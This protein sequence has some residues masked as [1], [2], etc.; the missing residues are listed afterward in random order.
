MVKK[1]S[2]RDPRAQPGQN[3]GLKT[4]VAMLTKGLHISNKRSWISFVTVSLKTQ[5][6]LWGKAA[7]RCAM[8]ACR[9]QLV[10]HIS[11]TDDPT[12]VGENCHIVAENDGG[13][14]SEPT[15]SVNDRNRYANLVLLCNVDH[16]IVDDN[17]AIWTA[18]AMKVLKAEHEAWVEGSLGLDKM[19]LRDETTYAEYVDEWVRLAHLNEWREWSSWVLGG[20][21]PQ[22]CTSVD[23]DLSILRRWLLGRVWP[24]RY[25]SLENAFGNFARV[26][27]DFQLTLH[28]YIEPRNEDDWLCTHK[29]YRIDQWDETLYFKL[30]VKYE[31]HVDIVCDLM[32]ELTRASNL[33]CHEVRRHVAHGFRLTEGNLIVQRG[34]DETLRVVE[35]VPH[36][37]QEEAALVTPYPGLPKFFDDRGNR[38]RVIGN[39]KPSEI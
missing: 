19:K 22:I 17:E 20:D 16:K 24:N 5:K 38:D 8:P 30:L 35:F 3:Q 28:K 37:S 34:P 36:Y 7:G 27:E 9:R 31:F 39:G 14:R 1:S 15:M 18:D 11:E 26:L 13:P 6:I 25:P 29:F 12:I 4:A 10:E 21:Q 33:V 2:G 23:K 32:L